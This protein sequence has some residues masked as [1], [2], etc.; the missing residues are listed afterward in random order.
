M[1]LRSAELGAHC[2]VELDDVLHRQIP[3]ATVSR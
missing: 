1:G 2:S 3:N